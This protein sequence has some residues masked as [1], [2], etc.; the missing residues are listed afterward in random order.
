MLRSVLRANR[1]SARIRGCCIC[2]RS[3]DQIVLVPVAGSV[4]LF[5]P[6]PPL[7]LYHDLSLPFTPLSFLYLV[8]RP[9]PLICPQKTKIPGWRSVAKSP[10]CGSK[11]RRI[12]RT[13]NHG[14]LPPR[15]RPAVEGAQRRNGINGGNPR[16][17]RRP[18][19]PASRI[20]VSGSGILRRSAT[21]WSRALLASGANAAPDAVQSSRR[22]W[23][24]DAIV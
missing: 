2:A 6:V 23:R 21:H 7:S 8:S 9:V 16:K 12:F 11:I 19:M 20:L 10:I 15:R 13:Q 17:G 18:F 1:R 4:G 14:N 5:R 22:H 3:R 24:T